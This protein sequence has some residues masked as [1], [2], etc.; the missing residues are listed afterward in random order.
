MDATGS[1]RLGCVIWFGQPEA[2][3]CAGLAEA[4]WHVRLAGD[5]AHVRVREGGGVVVLADLR[6]GD[7]R[8][9]Q[10]MQRMMADCP[11]L[12]WIA[13]ISLD[14]QAR[15][16]QV[17]RILQGCRDFF[18]APLDL[19]RLLAALE[20]AGGAASRVA[21]AMADLPELVG[22][23]AAMAAVAASLRK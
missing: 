21:E 12:P 9:L 14:T 5:D 7:A 15:R 16:P 11:G 4:G 3:E 13:L 20:R 17:K 2:R 6:H 23:S 18:S 10:A 22:R 8:T 1:R 19:P